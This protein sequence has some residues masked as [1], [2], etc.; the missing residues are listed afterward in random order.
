MTTSRHKRQ[1]GITLIE[2]LIGMTITTVISAMLITSWIALSDSYSFTTRDTKAREYARD[3]VRRLSREIRAAEA[4]PGYAPIR[5]ASSFSIQF[6]TLF[7]DAGAADVLNTSPILVGYRL[8]T[9]TTPGVYDLW[10][11]KDT[12]G[13]GA[14]SL[15]TTDSKFKVA[16]YVVRD[17][18]APIFQ[19]Y[20][21]DSTGRLAL[22]NSTMPTSEIVSVKIRLLIDLNPGKSPNRTEIVTTVQPRNSRQF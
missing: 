7:N 12:D 9:G 16:S 15:Y 2:L 21:Y 11:I 10:R 22:W 18:T 14:V 3:G 1:A 20:Y 5:R 13:N 17:Y 4:V 19:Y 8:R 6:T